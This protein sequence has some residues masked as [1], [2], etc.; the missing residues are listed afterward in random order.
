[1][2]TWN[3]NGASRG[4]GSL[5][6]GRRP[7]GSGHRPWHWVLLVLLAL[8]AWALPGPAHAQ[9]SAQV[10]GEVV[11]EAA[12]PAT[13][14]VAVGQATPP[15]LTVTFVEPQRYTDAGDTLGARADPDLLALLKRQFETSAAQCLAAGQTLSIRVL[16][17]DLAGDIDMAW[18]RFGDP[19]RVLRERARP[20]VDLAYMLTQ[21]A[22]PGAEVREQI[23]DRNFL[24]HLG[25]ARY[26]NARLPHERA[27]LA[28]WFEARF[29][30]TAAGGVY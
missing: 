28:R 11:S 20:R 14:A 22:V 1:M 16:D 5:L 26:D 29:C 24:M 13:G 6:P 3:W 12:G 21:G 17:V 2:F 7:T 8:L 25:Q 19:V 23:V 27:M 15:V 18:W 10:V 30:A 4:S 9:A